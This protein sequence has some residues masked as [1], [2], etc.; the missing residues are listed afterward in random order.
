MT[1]TSCVTASLGAK[2][3]F[4]VLTILGH[5]NPWIAIAADVRFFAEAKDSWPRQTV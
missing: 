5:T 1:S 4:V 2:A 3:V